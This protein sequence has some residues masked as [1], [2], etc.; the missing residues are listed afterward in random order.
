MSAGTGASFALLPSN[1]HILHDYP[2]RWLASLFSHN[3]AHRPNI[4]GDSPIC[5]NYSPN[6]T[7]TDT[8][9]DCDC[10][11]PAPK[12]RDALARVRAGKAADS[13]LPLTDLLYVTAMRAP[14]LSYLAS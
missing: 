3:P 6:P 10:E 12:T 5:S 8:T 9:A 14:H 13:L 11:R 2:S 7:L 4:P 1:S